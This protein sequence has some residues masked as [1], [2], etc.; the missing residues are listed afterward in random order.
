MD[1]D[2]LR[3][4]EGSLIRP[5]T[6]AERLWFLINGTLGS[7]Y[8]Y[9]SS[10]EASDES[11]SQTGG[12]IRV[13]EVDG[14]GGGVVRSPTPTPDR[15]TDVDPN[16]TGTPVLS[17]LLSFLSSTSNLFSPRRLVLFGILVLLLVPFPFLL[18][19]SSPSRRPPST[20]T[21]SSNILGNQ[22]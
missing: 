13:D 14:Q 16:S 5:T 10:R 19:P 20:L 22:T 3:L 2:G 8:V 18:L 1:K 15:L 17:L 7:E 6:Q 21:S 9:Q 12:S 11:L 4:G